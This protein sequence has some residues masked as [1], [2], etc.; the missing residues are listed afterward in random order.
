MSTDQQDATPPN[1]EFRDNGSQLS[2]PGATLQAARE[3]KGLTIA[4]AATS[5]RLPEKI[6]VHL[7]AG[8]FDKL[9]GDTF[10][11]GYIRSYARLL[12]L[13]AN[14]LVLEYDRSQGIEVRERQVSGIDKMGRPGRAGGMLVTWT[15]VIVALAILASILLWW[16]DSQPERS[17]E[18]VSAIA[19]QALDEVEVDAMALPE[20]FATDTD[21]GAEASE[22][23]PGPV[24]SVIDSDAAVEPSAEPVAQPAEQ[25]DANQAIASLETGDPVAQAAEE[26][27]P[28]AE[29]VE[30][31]PAEPVVAE[32]PT[33]TTEGLQMQFSGDCWLQVTTAGGE[34]LHSGLMRA[35]QS[36]NIDHQGPLDVV[37][38]AVEAVS[39]MTFNGQPVDTQSTRQSGV[40]RLRLG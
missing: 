21:P 12:G 26:E 7:E 22:A 17:I 32:S 13:D 9:P 8:R 24:S 19:S 20:D 3:Q 5:L 14:R 39:E 33:A 37:I 38:G 16:Y 40:V 25:S 36:L 30:Q 29:M 34:S 11:R 23:L 6:L 31:A 35:G 2:H 10:A 28:R 4:E 27:P 15:T 1:V 18:D